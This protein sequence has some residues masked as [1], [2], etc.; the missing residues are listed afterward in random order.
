MPKV[1]K[2]KLNLSSALHRVL[3]LVEREDRERGGGE[4]VRLSVR[5]VESRTER[6]FCV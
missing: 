3:V 6:M 2:H 4:D 1:Y 5:Y